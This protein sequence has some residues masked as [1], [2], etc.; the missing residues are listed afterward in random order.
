[1]SLIYDYPSHDSIIDREEL[2]ALGLPTEMITA[3]ELKNF[4]DLAQSLLAFDAELIKLLQNNHR[5]RGESGVR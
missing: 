1:M 5:K 2:H 3:D 4:M